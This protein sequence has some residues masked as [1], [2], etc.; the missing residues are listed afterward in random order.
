LALLAAT[1][2][3]LPGQ[4]FGAAT[5]VPKPGAD[6]GASFDSY[7]QGR[8]P[9]DKDNR[10]GVA[11]PSARQLA[12]ANRID[13]GVQWNA[14]GTPH[15]I[16]PV[17]GALATGLAA[18]P[19]TA[20]RQYLAQSSDLFGLDEKAVAGLEVVLVQPMGSG[21][22]VQLRQRFGDLV[23][24]YDGLVSILVSGGSVLRV[25]SS[26]SR[27]T[28]AAQ[29]P[30][31]SADEAFDAAVRDAGLTAEQVTGSDRRLV[32]VPTPVDGPR[33]AYA[34]TLIAPDGAAPTAFT[35]YVD[36]RTGD[37]LVREDNVDFDSDNPT[38]AVFP[39]TPPQSIPPGTDPRQIWCLNPAPGCL[40]TVSDPVTGQAYDFDVAAGAPTF[41]SRGNSA[42]SVV[43]WGAGNPPSN[44]TVSPN[45]DYRYP[46]TDQW[47]QNRCDPAAFTSTQRNDA[48]AATGRTTSGSPRRRGTCRRSTS[49][50]PAS[51]ATPSRA[52]RRRTRSAA[53][54]TTPT[55]ARR[56]TA[57]RRPRTCS[58][59]SRSPAARTRRASTATTT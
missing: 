23:A 10:A 17:Q 50:R 39:A 19:Q 56:A 13:R 24:G 57:C 22:V 2:I 49:V 20:A 58:C 34:V 18:D 47:H 30:T 4:A 37:V 12:A 7:P 26:L 16:G 14:L 32:A 3:V 48:D 28:R 8:G 25:S 38:W 1:A 55:R 27:D 33:A 51:A 59:G 21:T 52:G 42:N 36:A 6:S 40:R 43:N 9:R 15:A 46:F 31:I 11:A 35:T 54:A 5:A 29:A 53:A 45:R 41:T 44:A